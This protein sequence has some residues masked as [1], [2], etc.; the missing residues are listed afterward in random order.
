MDARASWGATQK[1]RN[2]GENY[3]ADVDGLRAVAVIIVVAFHALPPAVPGG[4]IGVDV[5][6]VISGFLITRLILDEQAVAAFSIRNFYVRRAKRILPALAIVIAATLLI[7]ACML[8]PAPYAKLGW[9][10]LA[11][12]LFFPNFAFWSEAGYFDSAAITKP[13]LHL[14]SLGVE[15]QFYLVWPLTLVLLRRSRVPLVAVLGII[16]ALSLVYSSVAAFSVPA[17][18]F[19]SPASRLW[20]LGAGGMLAAWPIKSRFPQVVSLIGLAIVVAAAFNITSASPFPGLLAVLPVAGTILVLIGRS[21]ILS[22]GPLVWLGLISYPLYLWHWPLLSFAAIRGAD[23][24]SARF[25]LVALSVILA[26]LTTRCVERPIR[27]GEWRYMGVQISTSAAALTAAIAFIVFFSN[28]LPIRYSVE[29]RPVLATMGTP[30]WFGRARAKTCWL[31]KDVPFHEYQPECSVGE[32]ALWGDSYS[33]LLGTGFPR[34]FAQFSRDGCLPLLTDDDSPCA[35]SNKLVVNE[36][37]RRKP[38][39][40]ILFA[41]WLFHSGDWQ[42]DRTRLPALQRTLHT[43]RSSI[44]DVVLVGPSPSWQPSLPEAVFKFWTEKGALPDRLK[45]SPQNYDSNVLAFR[46]TAQQEGAVFSSIF[47][48]LCDVDGCLTHTPASRSDLLMWDFGHLTL[49]GASYVTRALSLVRPHD[50]A[51]RTSAEKR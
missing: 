35:Q 47:D 4:F 32:V 19:Y 22:R 5:F 38:R 39:R 24:A 44:D 23:A 42:N 51:Y 3:R 30:T 29:I 6:F 27:F 15:E 45:P 26:W 49:D 34:P 21:W 17:A 40:V 43:L 25:G 46:R 16:S 36:L 9:H 11:G 13:L 10:A 1:A 7:G 48:S 33:A 31:A 12:A 14:W 37:L 8:L 50:M 28:G 2:V 41:A 20:E 18:A